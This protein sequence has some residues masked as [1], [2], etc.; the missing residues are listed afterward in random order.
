MAP[1]LREHSHEALTLNRLLQSARYAG[2]A[3][4]M[5]LTQALQAIIVWHKAHNSQQVALKCVLYA[6]ADQRVFT[7]YTNLED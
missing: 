5:N 6:S 1:P 2:L 3:C 4:A 7:S